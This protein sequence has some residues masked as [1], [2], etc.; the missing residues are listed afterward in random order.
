MRVRTTHPNVSFGTDG[1]GILSTRPAFCGALSFKTKYPHIK[2]YGYFDKTRVGLPGILLIRRFRSSLGA[3]VPRFRSLRSLFAFARS[4]TL[5]FPAAKQKSAF[6]ALLFLSGCWESNPVYTHPKRAYYR[7]TTARAYSPNI[8]LL[9]EF[10][11]NCP[12]ALGDGMKFLMDCRN[13]T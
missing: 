4:D 3:G 11:F 12:Q 13:S 9:A 7:Y 5:R 6:G 8:L 1:L 10:F 2:M